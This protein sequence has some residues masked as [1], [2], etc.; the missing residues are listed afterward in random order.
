MTMQ[1]GMI[2]SDGIVLASDTQWT[3]TVQ[4]TENGQ[5]IGHPVRHITHSSKIKTNDQM[6]VSYAQ[7]K[8]TSHDTANAI[9]ACFPCSDPEEAIKQIAEDIPTENRQDVQGLIAIPPFELFR[10]QI[11][12]EN[13]KWISSCEP[14]F[15]FDVA[16]DIANRAIFW[17][18]RYHHDWLTTEQLIPLAAHMIMAS[19]RIHT[20]FIGGLE[21]AICKPNEIQSLPREETIRLGREAWE[22][23]TAITEMIFGK[24]VSL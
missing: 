13:G 4:K 9:L 18:Y 20:G 11:A 10:F 17:I 5:S 24:G 22:R 7:D 6:A 21:I 23:D 2:G 8:N 12:W 1:I 16:G 15:Q 3:S 14:N 19:H